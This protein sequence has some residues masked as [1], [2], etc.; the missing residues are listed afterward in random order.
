[1]GDGSLETIGARLDR[2]PVT[3]FHRKVFTLV[4]I[5]M[6][7]DGF[8]IYIAGSVLGAAV[9]DK[10]STVAQNGLFIS[11]TFVG[12][13]LGAGVTG[14]A[15][16]RFG[17]RINYQINLA[18]FG[19]AALAAAMAPNMSALIAIRFV[20]GLGLGAEAVV[21]YSIITEFVPPAVRGR[22][23]GFIA[24]IVTSGLPVS[25]LLAYLLVP[26]F[27]WRVMFVL[28]GIGALTVWWLRKG[29]PESPRWLASAGRHAEADAIVAAIE[30]QAPAAALQAAAAP[31]RRP[32]P[33][34]VM[35]LFRAPLAFQMIVGCVSLIAVNMLIFGF[36]VWLPTFLVR[37]GLSIATSFG[38]I[39]VMSLGGPAGSG[40]GAFLADSV[41]R[42]PTIIG[43]ALAAIVFGV[44]F[45]FAQGAVLVSLLGFLMTVPVYILVT[46]FFGIYIPEMFPTELRLRAT[47]MCNMA[48]RAASIVTPLAVVPLFAAFGITGVVALMVAA[49][50]VMIAV[51]AALGIEPE[52]KPLEALEALRA[53]E[54]EAVGASLV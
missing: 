48:G 28:G 38:Y 20:M 54:S 29:L 45:L 23:S 49:L 8:D 7:F 5:G 12:M 41:G 27:G 42:K 34:G 21:G 26:A 50:A 16:D 46:L 6:F 32:A 22:W 52:R 44:S 18:V 40:A 3:A 25:A 31:R 9:H 17:R 43:A 37:Q 14:F 13:M 53:A 51:V 1:M 19:V 2:L 30:A 11:V 15:G 10:F 47:G 39:F 33:R 36:I 24:T 4:A 35:D